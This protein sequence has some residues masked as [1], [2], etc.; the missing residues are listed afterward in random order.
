[1]ADTHHTVYFELHH[2]LA[3][4][5]CALCALAL[6]SM[7]RYF[8]ALGYESVN[9]PGIRDAIRAA[10]GFCEVHARMLREARDALGTAIIHRDVVSTAIGALDELAYRPTSLGDLLRQAIGSERTGSTNGRADVL[11]PQ[12]PCPACMR[13][14]TTDQVYVDALLQHL[15]DDDLLPGFRHSAGLCLPHLRLALQ[16]TPDAATFD[17]LKTA[18]LTI[19]Q[20]LARELDEFIRKQDHRFAAEPLGD[21]RN[22]WSRAV[23]LVSGQFGLGCAGWQGGE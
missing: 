15:T 11:A 6:R 7:R 2:A 14:Q 5:G 8:E 22:A 16:R 9:D 12:Q 18:Q 19:W 4:P 10:R 3:G 13:R 1:M 23:D 17:R 20:H 21:E